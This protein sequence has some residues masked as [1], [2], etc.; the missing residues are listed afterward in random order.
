MCGKTIT[1]LPTVGQIK[2]VNVQNVDAQI[3]S[4]I[5]LTLLGGGVVFT[6]SFL[7][8]LQVFQV[9][10]M[11]LMAAMAHRSSASGSA[12]Y[13]WNQTGFQ[14]YQ[15]IST[16]GALAWRHFFMGKKVCEKGEREGGRCRAL[17]CWFIPVFLAPSLRRIWWCPTSAEGLRGIPTQSHWWTSPWFTSGAKNENSLWRSRLYAPTVHETGRPSKSTGTP[18]SLWQITD[19]VMI[20]PRTNDLSD[21]R[22]STTTLLLSPP[23]NLQV[24]TITL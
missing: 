16:Y 13:T 20:C 14:L 8:E 17:S 4:F 19:K 5:R 1:F 2:L 6:V 18:T 3:Q 22:L 9:P 7:Y 24:I 23:F 15:N 21:G 12:V 11:G 10:G